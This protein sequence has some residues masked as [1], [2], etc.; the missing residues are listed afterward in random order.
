VCIALGIVLGL[1]LVSGTAN[2][3]AEA[4]S[5]REVFDQAVADFFAGDVQQAAVG[6]DR[7][8]ELSP[9]DAPYLWQRGITLY[10]VGRF[11]DCRTQFESHRAVNP[12]DVENAVWH[13]LCVARAESPASAREVLLPVGPDARSPM[14]EIYQMFSGALAPGAVLN[15]AGEEPRAQFYARLYVGLYAEA[16]GD[17][18]TAREQIVAAA[19]DRFSGPGNY[20]HRVARVHA[21]LRGWD[22]DPGR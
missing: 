3:E 16:L 7:V 4:Q 19:A 20:M 9:A 21:S 22:A 1:A 15:A 17:T 2:G 8:V 6:F 18:A 5:A 14:A 10:Y 12:N 13:F 11:D